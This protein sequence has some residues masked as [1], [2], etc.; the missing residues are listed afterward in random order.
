MLQ[1][2]TNRGRPPAPVRRR[3]NARNHQR[4]FSPFCIW[5][6]DPVQFR[7]AVLRRLIRGLIAFSTQ[8]VKAGT[9]PRISWS[10]NH[11]AG[12][13]P[14]YGPPTSGNLAQLGSRRAIM[15]PVPMHELQ[16]A[17]FLWSSPLVQRATFESR[18]CGWINRYS[19]HRACC[20]PDH[21]RRKRTRSEDARGRAF[22]GATQ[23]QGLLVEGAHWHP[24]RGQ[25][26]IHTRRL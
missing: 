19:R 4:T 22:I 23:L 12:H 1:L 18:E 5:S 10:E 17:G 16:T 20:R 3:W 24:C 26:E 13:D 6:A 7:A 2:A 11:L 14:N 15:A 8:P 25:G 21:E 9:F